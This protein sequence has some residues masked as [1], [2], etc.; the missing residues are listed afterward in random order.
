MTRLA[1][2]GAGLAGLTLARRLSNNA[3]ITVFEKSRGVSGRLSTRRLGDFEFDHGAQFFTARSK[4]FQQF[5]KP[6]IDEGVVAEWSPRVTT[7]SPTAKP[8][9]REWFEP[10]YVAVPRMNSLCKIIASSLDLQLNTAVTKLE[11]KDEGWIVHTEGSTRPETFDWVISTAPVEQTL[12]LFGKHLSDSLPAEDIALDQACMSPC[13][14]LM[15]GLKVLPEIHFDAAKVNDSCLEWIMVNSSKPGRT[16]LPT[17]VIQST[18][19]WAQEHLE[20]DEQWIVDQMLEDLEKVLPQSLPPVETHALH[21]WL[22]ARVETPLKP[23][24]LIDHT[25]QLAACGDWCVH[26]RVEGA[27]HSALSLARVLE[28]HL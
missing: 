26:G 6:F 24:F 20:A 11:Q 13:F 16:A 15:L 25:Q 8:F 12:T 2:I 18:N 27:F 1:I 28:S 5:L 19:A 9:K 7:L 21:R 22:Y 4:S 17:L 23:D 3:K 10:H 14:T